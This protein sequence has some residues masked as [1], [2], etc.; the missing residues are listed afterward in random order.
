MKEEERA[1][2]LDDVKKYLGEWGIKY[3]QEH[4]FSEFSCVSF[5]VVKPKFAIKI[6]VFKNEVWMTSGNRLAPSIEIRVFS[7]KKGLE[8]VLTEIGVALLP[9]PE[10]EG[11]CHKKTFLCSCFGHASS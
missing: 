8:A 11:E 1:L 7:E 6:Y 4:F 2:T 3:A 10:K 9:S 5:T